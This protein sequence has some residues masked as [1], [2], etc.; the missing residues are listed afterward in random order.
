MRRT[1]CGANTR[2][3]GRARS[4][5]RLGGGTSRSVAAASAW[6]H[7]AGSSSSLASRLHRAHRDLRRRGG[8]D[9]AGGARPRGRAPR[10][11]RIARVPRR[12]LE[13]RRRRPTGSCRENWSARERAWAPELLGR[14]ARRAPSVAYRSI[15]ASR[16][17]VVRRR[18]LRLAPVSDASAARSSRRREPAPLSAAPH[19]GPH[20]EPRQRREDERERLRRLPSAVRAD[21]LDRLGGV[22][23]EAEAGV[24]AREPQAERALGLRARAVVARPRVRVPELEHEEAPARHVERPARAVAPSRARVGGPVSSKSSRAAA[25]AGCSRPWASISATTR[26]PGSW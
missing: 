1:G 5:R 2:G 15:S 25:C 16:A 10:A 23:R 21:H 17:V 20:A 9:A 22:P 6:W 18:P 7:G 19:A 4:P 13:P 24:L 3:T 11:P 8:D 26:P 12:R 14:R